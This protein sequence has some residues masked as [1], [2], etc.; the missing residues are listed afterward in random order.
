LGVVWRIGLQRR[1]GLATR[2]AWPPPSPGARG[3]GRSRAG[4][5]AGAVV[6]MAGAAPGRWSRRGRSHGLAGAAT[7]DTVRC[8]GNGRAQALSTA[9]PTARRLPPP[10]ECNLSRSHS[11]PQP[12]TLCEALESA[13][14][15]R[16]IRTRR[17][18]S[19]RPGVD[20]DNEQGPSRADRDSAFDFWCDLNGDGGL[21][22]GGTCPRPCEEN[23][24][25]GRLHD[26]ARPLGCADSAL[27]GRFGVLSH[28][29]S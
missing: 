24:V 28:T 8:V 23:V 21:I 9:S 13:P 12:T 26:R 14:S 20:I 11:R 17:A 2:L 5:D 29:L 7:G 27:R 16:R 22:A 19:C 18:R 6:A 4:G 3:S 25:R 1:M 10:F 15:V